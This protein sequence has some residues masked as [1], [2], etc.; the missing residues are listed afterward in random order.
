MSTTLSMWLGIAFLMLA[1]VA[2]LLQAWLWGPKFW[3][4]QAKKTRAPKLWL[5]MHALAGYSYGVIYVVMMW[6]M[7]PRLWEYQYELPA[8]TVIHAVLAIAIGVLL[9]CK[10][11]ILLFFRHFEEAMPRYGFGLL[12]CTVAMTTLSVPYAL[13]AHDLEGRTTDPGNVERVRKLLAEVEIDPKVD[14]ETLVTTQA[15]E[16]GREVLVRKCI[17]CHDMRTVLVQPRTAKG[18]YTVNMR[19]LEK[20]AVFGERLEPEDVP[21]VTAYLVAITPEIQESAKQKREQSRMVMARTDAMVAAVHDAETGAA[22]AVDKAAGEALLQAKC[23]DCHE[24]D[25]VEKHGGDDVAGWRSVIA[26]MVDEG[27]ELTDEEA[28][29]LTQYLAAIHPAKPKPAVAMPPDEDE[30]DEGDDEGVMMEGE[31]AS[32]ARPTEGDAKPTEGD[33]KPT[34]GDT[35]PTEGD[36]KPTEGDAKPTEGD[37]KPVVKKK[38]KPKPK[39]DKAAGRELFMAKCKSCHGDD[40][41][42]NTPFGQKIG[43]VSLVGS[44]RSHAQIRSITANGVPGTKMKPYQGKLTDKE[45]DDVAAFVKALR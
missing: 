27:T 31:D 2:V 20:P 23:V 36:A 15:F 25:E 32:D 34:E 45:L 13:R 1:I 33:T 7:L 40:G 12:V 18:W 29:L 22:P 11:A 3:D 4:D 9:I 16:R 37:A 38:A 35:K 5:R 6:F 39:G 44:G 8:R 17:T 30:G 24:L 26:A 21:F 10:I 41:K 19:M 43:I 28:N 42:G 14:V